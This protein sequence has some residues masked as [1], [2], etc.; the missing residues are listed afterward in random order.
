MSISQEMLIAIQNWLV[1]YLPLWKILVLWV[2]GKHDIP[3]MEWTI[4]NV[5]N[6]QPANAQ[7]LLLFLLSF[8][9]WPNWENLEPSE[10]VT[11]SSSR[12]RQGSSSSV[13]TP[14]MRWLWRC[15]ELKQHG[16]PF[17]GGHNSKRGQSTT[18]GETMGIW[19][20][21]LRIADIVAKQTM[22]MPILSYTTRCSPTRTQVWPFGHWLKASNV[23]L[24][25]CGFCL[26]TSSSGTNLSSVQSTRCTRNTIWLSP[27]FRFMAFDHPQ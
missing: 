13:Q 15:D 19:Q 21:I 20:P 24:E 22:T 17:L 9:G 1:V 6:H 8:P 2:N 27:G 25:V 16:T 10:P 12:P 11:P 7:S 3:D 4:K 23:M 26:K 14:E 5:W 18:R